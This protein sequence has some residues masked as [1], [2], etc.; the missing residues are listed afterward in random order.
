MNLDPLEVRVAYHCA[1]EV[2]RRR[3][4]TGE[5]IPPSLRELFARLDLEVRTSPDPAPP[6]VP[7]PIGSTTAAG[8]LGCT[9]RW[10]QHIAADLDGQRV[11][12]RW[13]FSRK[14]V[15]E[16]AEMRRQRPE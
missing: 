11:D 6:E 15:A 8:L 9:V 10:V 16:Y 4:R 7:D 2:M 13:L 14:A 5:P 3:R 1:A 12:G